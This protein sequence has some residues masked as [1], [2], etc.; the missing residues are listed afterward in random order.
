M[1]VTDRIA[2]KPPS[3]CIPISNNLVTI[4]VDPG[5]KRLNARFPARLVTE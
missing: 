4:G 2:T 5:V 3:C 1:V